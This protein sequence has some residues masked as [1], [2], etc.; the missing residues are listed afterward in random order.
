MK[1]VLFAAKPPIDQK[2]V[3]QFTR[4]YTGDGT[5]VVPEGVY[6]VCIL[7]IGAGSPGWV[8]SLNAFGG[9]GGAV[10][11]KNDIPVT[12]G[13]RLDFRVASAGDYDTKTSSGNIANIP[14]TDLSTLLGIS[15]GTQNAGTA[16]GN[17]VGGGDGG[18]YDTSGYDKLNFGGSVGNMDGTNALN[19]NKA[20]CRGLSPNTM[21]WVNRVAPDNKG[22]RAG[23][24]GAAIPVRRNASSLNQIW[25]GGHGAVRIIWG[26]G[27]AYPSTKVTDQPTVA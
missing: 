18:V 7:V 26:E 23:G 20:P 1:N 13:Q 19:G 12:P 17:G 5:F 2:K 4:Q 8:Y 22:Q 24:G 6:S 16:L 27:R 25:R 21:Q 14:N 11:W 10:R 3:G 9:L 15:A